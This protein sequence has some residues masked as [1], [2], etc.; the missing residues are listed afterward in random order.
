MM[1]KEK[2]LHD[3]DKLLLEV[4]VEADPELCQ[5]LFT[6]RQD[7]AAAQK[8]S[9]LAM[10]QAELSERLAYYL[11]THQYQAP[12]SVIAFGYQLAGAPHKWQGVLPTLQMLALSLLGMGK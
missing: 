9:D 2:V 7:L 11:M 3:L 12:Q 8:K 6:G 1:G 10:A 5:L 4:S